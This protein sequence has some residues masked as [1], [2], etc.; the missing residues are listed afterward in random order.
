[1]STQG[2]IATTRTVRLCG[3]SRMEG[4]SDGEQSRTGGAPGRLSVLWRRRLRPDWPEGAHS[5]VLRCVCRLPFA[6]ATDAEMTDK[7]DY[8]HICGHPDAACDAECADNFYANQ[9]QADPRPACPYC[10]PTNRSICP[11]CKG[12]G[13]REAPPPDYSFIGVDKATGKDYSVEAPFPDD[14][15]CTVTKSGLNAAY[16]AGQRASREAER[17]AIAKA[18][19]NVC[20]GDMGCCGWSLSL[21]IERG[22][23]ARPSGEEGKDGG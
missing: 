20:S 6:E 9:R 3:P 16:A 14:D 8:P 2:P 18:V 17:R 19:R 1:M 11:W 23:F 12:T 22:D 10:N 7:P 5:A 21:R 4:E 13:Q 15:A